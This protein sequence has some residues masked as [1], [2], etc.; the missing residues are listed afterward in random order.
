MT[1]E[2]DGLFK[3]LLPFDPSLL[4]LIEK[5]RNAKLIKDYNCDNY[6]ATKVSVKLIA[7]SY[8]GSSMSTI[9]P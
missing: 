1:T 4:W 8:S 2:R 6:R 5:D 9:S 7:N 3:I